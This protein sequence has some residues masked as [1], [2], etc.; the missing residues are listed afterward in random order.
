MT[1]KQRLSASVDAELIAAAEHAVARGRA[2]TVSAWVNHALEL[3]VAHDRR[4]EALAAF[5]AEYEAEHGRITEDEMRSA[6][7]RARRRSVPSRG[8]D[9]PRRG[10]R[11]RA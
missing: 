10:G 3:K 9:R 7:R 1:T 4:I 6:A 5:I 11:S 2:K 8:V